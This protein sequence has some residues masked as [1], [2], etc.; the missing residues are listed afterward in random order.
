[1]IKWPFLRRRRVK[2]DESQERL[3]ESLTARGNYLA[4]RVAAKPG[5]SQ[6]LADV[7]KR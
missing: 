4:A 3:V 2:F 6:A 5:E 1:M 7:Q